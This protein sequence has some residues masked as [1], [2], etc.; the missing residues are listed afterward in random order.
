M[1]EGDYR[2]EKIE[3]MVESILKIA[4]E[5]PATLDQ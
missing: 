1:M 4:A 5:P 3:R 2:D